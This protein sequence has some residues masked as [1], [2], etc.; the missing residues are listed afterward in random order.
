MRMR[1]KRIGSWLGMTVASFL[2]V[3]ALQALPQQAEAATCTTA[4]PGVNPASMTDPQAA[5]TNLYT[6]NNPI[7]DATRLQKYVTPV[8][9]ALSPGFVYT[10]NGTQGGETLYT[11]SMR[12]IS[13]SLGIIDAISGCTG[14]PNTLWAYGDARDNGVTTAPT[15]GH[16]V[17]GPTYEVM[18]NVPHRVLYTNELP[19][20]NPYYHPENI[21]PTLDCGPNAPGCSPYN[22]VVPHTHGAHVADDSDGN[23]VQWFTPGF[24]KTGHNWQPNTHIPGA[25]IGTYRF[26]NT[27][28]ASTVWYHDHAMGLTHL[29]VFAGL[30]GFNIIRDANEI[31]MQ[32][33]VG[34]APALLPKYPFE[35]LLA[36]QD[37][38]FDTNGKQ[39]SP[40]R[41]IQDQNYI[42]PNTTPCDATPGAVA[43]YACVGTTNPT[44][45]NVPCDAAA[46]IVAPVS[47]YACP[48][49]YFT[50]NADGSV[51]VIPTG[52]A[53]P[54][55]ALTFPSITS[56]Y[57][58][59][60]ITVNGQVWP[61][62]DTEKRVYRQRFLN[63]SDS[64]TYILRL[65]D[66]TTRLP[67]AGLDIWQ[68]GT[69]Q[70]F[71]P[72]PVKT[73]VD[74]TTATPLPTVAPFPQTNGIVLMPGERV[75]VLIDF[76]NVPAGTQ[77]VLQNLGPD[78]PYTGEYPDALNANGQLPTTI[79]PEV[80][81][82]NVV[83][84]LSATPNTLVPNLITSLRPAPVPVLTPTATRTLYLAE[85]VDRF[86]RLAL[87]IN[88]VDYMTAI[89]QMIP[90]GAT[91]QWDI[92]NLTPD[93]HP[94][95]PHLVAFEVINR[96]DLMVGAVP[97]APPM[98][99]PMMGTTALQQ[100]DGLLG[101]PVMPTATGPIY[102]PAANEVGALKD[103]IYTPPGKVTRIKA[104]FD[105]PGLY[106]FHCHI[107]SHEENDMMRPFAV[108]T[109]V[110]SVTLTASNAFTP[111]GTTAP[112]TFTAAAKTADP[113]HPDSN[114]FEYEFTI[115]SPTG[116]VTPLSQTAMVNGSSMGYSMVRTATWNTPTVPGTYVVTVNAKPMG[117]AVTV[118]P[119]TVTLNYV[120]ASPAI[121][122][123]STTTAAGA[124]KAGAPANVT[125]LFNQM[126]T[127]AAGLTVALN[128]GATLTT[129]PLTTPTASISLPYT[130]GATD[131]TPAG[132]F[133]DVTG[134]TGTINDAAN[135]SVSTLAVPA[136]SNISNSTKIQIDNTLPTISQ[137]LPA[138][139]ATFT[140][141]PTQTLS[142]TVSD[143]VGIQS[144]T[145]NGAAVSLAANGT[146]STSSALAVNS[147]NTFTCVATDMAGNQTTTSLAVTHDNTLPAVAITS[148]TAQYV[149]NVNQTV[150]GTATDPVGFLSVTVNG[151]TVTPDATGAFTA[152][153]I[154]TAGT[155]N[156]IT[157][158]GTDKAGNQTT[159]TKTLTHS[160]ILPIVAFTS[161]APFVNTLNQTVAGT[162]TSPVGIHSVTINGVSQTLGTGGTFSTPITLT[163]NVANTITVVALDNAGNQAASNLVVTHDTTLPVTTPNPPPGTYSGSVSVALAANKQ[164]A[165]IYYTT[166]G[167]VPTTASTKYVIGQ[168]IVLSS[169]TTATKKLMYFAV[170]QAGNVEAVKT[171]SYTLHTTD[172]TARIAINAGK[173]FTAT[174]N[175]TLAMSASDRLKVAAYAIS[176]DGGATYLPTVAI[177]PPVI[178]FSRNV[179]ITLPSG[180]GLK[181]VF[182]KFTDGVGVVYA[183]S[184]AQITLDTTPAA[185][186]AMPYPGPYPGGT[187]KVTLTA[188]ESATIY[189]TTNGTTPTKASPIY[190]SPFNIT[191]T[192]SSV[193]VKYF[194][195]DKSGNQE[196]VKTATYTFGH[197]SDMTASFKINGGKRYTNSKT[198]SLSF[199]ASDP[200]SGGVA[201]MSFSNDGINF[202]PVTPY[203]PATAMTWALTPGDAVKTVYVRFTDKFSPPNTYTYS[204]QII[205]AEGVTL[206]TGDVNGDG[207]VDI[208]DASL[209][210]SASAGLRTLSIP[211]QARGDVGPLVGGRPDPDGGIDAG[212]ALTITQKAVGIV[213]F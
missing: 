67:I 75:D 139:P 150:T 104:T 188:D 179:P 128:S 35:N 189:Y 135:Y 120:I 7:L 52:T 106:V 167:N 149:N 40:D 23:P 48:V 161:P 86:G 64:R 168:P 66:K 125:V 34:T 95:H 170:D 42:L 174:A 100:F 113:A 140:N 191:G 147:T 177:A 183:P 2:T 92:V 154:L 111:S 137:A 46:S 166:T 94:M 182:V 55:G 56:E 208:S 79:V 38:V 112:V 202:T 209:A 115:T 148:P 180:D 49:Q 181:N 213:S 33:P 136:G 61:K 50:R 187:M 165:T 105:I 109:P 107:L 83:A 19:N 153:V 172:L 141:S 126:V 110:N 162:A 146:Y 54:A 152:P 51:N 68:I 27:Q 16:S 114:A 28:E 39:Y 169:P 60:V 178:T 93:G 176:V 143:P 17:P 41:P 175:V 82:Y 1:C 119:V 129:G 157:V 45:T 9:N 173:A 212:D 196:A 171:S 57:W 142:G 6:F 151:A 124:L 121:A 15:A 90:L 160:A 205:L 87:T 71:L 204:D 44:L 156:T 80:M 190:R 116:T 88:G 14:P 184:M 59:N 37:K 65:V 47:P 201:S 30:A 108:T 70:G 206:A 163:A 211:E 62:Q 134:I 207:R 98:T 11:V 131:N 22:R 31:A 210:L 101:N 122:G 81:L 102:P 186:S 200:A 63:G 85:R 12:E 185:S 69:E 197:R 194:A 133:L 96:Q 72:A 32:T 99:L 3:A 73:M 84:T 53:P 199:S 18:S 76:T 158:V 203:A 24:A 118:L 195:V 193:T 192:N 144:L 29:N 78:F 130:V 103:T 74:D 4:F 159:A 117:A 198:V 123:V 164:G 138:A 21:D 89:D 36:I 132:Q 58:G 97:F 145:I 5:L 91:E 155:V 26:E 13:Q 10:P 25:T 20:A 43:P 8:P 77:V 127:S